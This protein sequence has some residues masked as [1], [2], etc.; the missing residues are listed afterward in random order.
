M[1]QM[2]GTVSGCPLFAPKHVGGE[3]IYH[4]NSTNPPRRTAEWNAADNNAVAER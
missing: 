2:S 3:G 4:G 1:S